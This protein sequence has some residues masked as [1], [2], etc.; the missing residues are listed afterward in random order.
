MQVVGTGLLASARLAGEGGDVSELSKRLAE[1][2]GDRSIDS[3]VD[4]AVK[5]GHP[6]SRAAVAKY[7]RGDH[8]PRPPE[9]TLVGLA[10]GLH[11]DVRELRELASRPGGELEPWIPP[12]V[13]AS[14]T[15]QQREALNR[16][17]VAFVGG[18]DDGRTPDAQKSRR[19]VEV[20]RRR[21]KPSP[22]S[23]N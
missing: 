20:T 5:R 21:A 11:L 22:Q 7:V 3:V 17:I 15:R 12:A 13:S 19:V 4:E 23:P 14:L 9:A 8:G 2:K 18:G 6:I 1:A 16:L 10:A